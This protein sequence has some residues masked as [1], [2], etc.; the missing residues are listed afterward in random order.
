[1]KMDKNT[2][3]GLVL[4]AVLFFVFFW[5]TS[6]QQQ[7]AVAFQKQ[8]QDSIARVKALNAPKT[9]TAQARLDSLR[10]DSL[11]KSGQA[12]NFTG[13]GNGTEQ[14]TVVE[15][16]LLKAIFSNKGGVL[17]SVELK[18]YTSSHT[19][20]DVVIGG[21][22]ED[23]LGYLINTSP[24]HSAS[25]ASLFFSAPQVVKNADSSQ[26]ISFILSN[27]SGERIIHQYIIRPND[28][29][30]DWNISINGA[31]RLFRRD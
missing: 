10:N 23:N 14:L 16:N 2:V 13:A 24:N 12:G 1:M 4:L 19:G 9:D 22:P 25:T 20:K 26:S 15:N 30:I 3:I 27:A 5:Y 18:N 7:A 8:Q 28:Y 21:Q 29:M 17:K 11:I 31:D 6:K